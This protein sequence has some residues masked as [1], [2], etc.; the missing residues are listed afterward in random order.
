MFDQ[1]Q[2]LSEYLEKEIYFNQFYYFQKEIFNFHKE[3]PKLI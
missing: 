3:V 1:F 2:S